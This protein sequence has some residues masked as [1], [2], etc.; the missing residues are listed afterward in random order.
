MALA[1][2]TFLGEYKRNTKSTNCRPV[3]QGYILLLSV[4]CFLSPF[5][6]MTYCYLKVYLKV[7]KQRIQLQS[8]RSNSTNMKTELK[9]AKIVF[10]VLAVFLVCWLPFVTVYILSNSGKSQDIS[11]V[12]FLLSGCLAA[13]HSVCNPVIYFTMNRSFRNDLMAW[14]IPGLRK[15]FNTR[16]SVTHAATKRNNAAT[17]MEIK[18]NEESY[19]NARIR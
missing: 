12:I 2:I 8:W 7:R 16:D 4:A 6:T 9:T 1:P 19:R 11:P 14:L 18:V 10:T 15:F 13:A 17:V 5:V 3:G